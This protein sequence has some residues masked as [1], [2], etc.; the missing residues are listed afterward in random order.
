MREAMAQAGYEA[1]TV[2]YSSLPIFS[3][4]NYDYPLEHFFPSAASESAWRRA[5][6]M[7]LGPYW[8]FLWSLRR[9]DV[10]HFFFDG[11]LLARTPLRF[12]EVQLL[13]LAG[14]KVVVFPYGGD[15]AALS[16]IRPPPGAGASSSTIPSSSVAAGRSCARSG[17]SA[18]GPTSWSRTSSMPSRSRDAIS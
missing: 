6:A 10:F 14:K 16:T 8:V 5:P 12:L 9:F 18:S 17:T 13:H 1:R 15:V 4:A 3:Q 11:G 2:V 7:I